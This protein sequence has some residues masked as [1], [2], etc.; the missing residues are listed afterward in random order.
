[1]VTSFKSQAAEG[2]D[3]A[4]LAAVDC[5]H[6]RTTQVLVTDGSQVAIRPASTT[7]QK[8][9]EDKG[10][11]LVVDETRSKAKGL[12]GGVELHCHPLLD[13]TNDAGWSKVDGILPPGETCS[14][15]GGVEETGAGG[16]QKKA[17]AAGEPTRSQRSL[18]A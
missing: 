10:Y 1:V 5:V 17:T 6:A 18:G 12:H 13:V 11:V 9:L 15:L 16:R 8:V 4:L 7:L 2:V 14:K 3:K